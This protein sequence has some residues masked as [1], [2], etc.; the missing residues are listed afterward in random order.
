MT[1]SFRVSILPT[2]LVALAPIALLILGGSSGMF[3]ALMLSCMV[4]AGTRAGEAWSRLRPYGWLILALCLPLAATL[5]SQ[6][7]THTWR[8][9]EI[10]RA[11]R[12]SLAFPLL[13]AGLAVLD[14]RLL[15]HFVWG[16]LAASAA[17]FAVVF[18]LSWPSFER[19]VTPQFNAVSYG[20]LMLLTGVLV[21][22]SLEWTL[23]RM[24]TLEKY[25]KLTLGC[26]AFLGFILT[27]TRTGW[28]AVPLFAIIAL[29]LSR[30][31]RHPLRTLAIL[32]AIVAVLAA[33]GAASS[34]LRDRVAQGFQE[35]RQCETVDQTA[36]TSMCIRLQLWRSAWAMFQAHPWTGVGNGARFVEELKLRGQQGKVSAY[37]AEGFGETHNDLLMALAVHGVPGVLAMLVLYLAPAWLFLRRMQRHHPQA[38]RTAAAMGLAICLGFAIFGLTELMFRGMRSLSFYVT[39]LAVLAVLSRPGAIPDDTSPQRPQ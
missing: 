12:V 6:T 4:V 39:M 25:A 34:G 10:E 9:T 3:Y 27:Q 23:T 29:M 24:P 1:S 19:P 30:R 7:V 11:W 21:L 38:G 13:L 15:R 22:Y 37:V 14:A 18:Y 31:M 28:L 36:D 2:V 16:L 20:N 8:S 17:S 5:F 33:A 35:V 26:A 32:V